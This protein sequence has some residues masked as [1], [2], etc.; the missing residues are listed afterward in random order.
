MT[1]ERAEVTARGT[2]QHRCK[3]NVL[4]TAACSSLAAVIMAVSLLMR[5]MEH[6]L[7]GAMPIGKVTAG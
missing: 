3:Q 7:H 6:E 2:L 1:R 5:A 4:E